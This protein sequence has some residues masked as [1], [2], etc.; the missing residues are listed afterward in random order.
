MNSYHIIVPRKMT[1]FSFSVI[2][3]TI[4]E[5]FPRNVWVNEE[6]VVKHLY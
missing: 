2:T 1:V 4:V 5:K 3:L 6:K